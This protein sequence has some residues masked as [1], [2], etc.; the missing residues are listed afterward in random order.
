MD[1]DGDLGWSLCSPFWGSTPHCD[2]FSTLAA[3]SFFL[4]T[5]DRDISA[6]QDLPH[7]LHPPRDVA[8]LIGQTETEAWEL[9]FQ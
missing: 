8:C 4:T 9:P 7:E 3:V 5:W 6:I 2:P 1:Q